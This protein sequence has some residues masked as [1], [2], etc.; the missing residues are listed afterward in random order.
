MES[1][2]TIHNI[3]RV[4]TKRETEK[5]T[6]SGRIGSVEGTAD[7]NSIVINGKTLPDASIGYLLHFSLQSL[8]D[9]YAGAADLPE[10]TANFDK[11][12][13]ALMEG[14]IG[15]RSGGGGMSDEEKAELYVAE[16]IY[17]AVHKKGSEKGDAFRAL[18]GDD[19][20]EFLVEVITK[21][22]AQMADFQDRVDARVASVVAARKARA[23][24]VAGATGDLDL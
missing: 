16:A 24:V 2:M 12:L 6:W 5:S 8:Q 1:K 13:L 7:I 22:R 3:A 9:A 18:D 21:L 23:E 11:K 10:A 14:T 20:Y 15:V 4:F 17:G 19:K